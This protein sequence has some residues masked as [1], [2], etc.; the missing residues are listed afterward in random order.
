[1]KILVVDDEEDILTVIETLLS[2]T[3]PEHTIITVKESEKG[4][5]LIQQGGINLV[6]TDLRMAGMGGEGLLKAIQQFNPLI[7]VLIMS[8][9]GS[10][11][12]AVSLVKS[13]ARDFIT[14]PFR[15]DDFIHRV[16]L[17]IETLQLKQELMEVRQ[18]LHASRHESRLLYSSRAM[19]AIVSRASMAA[20]SSAPILISGE[21][22]T[23]KE[24]IAREI[25]ALSDRNDKPFIAIN[26]GAFPETLLEAELFGYRRGAFTGAVRDHAGIIMEAAEGTLF[27]D[28]IGETSL[29]FQVKLLRFI[30]EGEIRALGEGRTSR[31]NTRII[32][33]T[34]RDLRA[35]IREGSFRD[36]LFYRLNV[37]PIHIPP[38]RD[39][40][41]DILLL[42]NTFLK[43]FAK[44][45][46]RTLSLSPLAA[47]KLAGYSW[48][49]N[50]RELENRI[51][52]ASIL[53]RTNPILPED[54]E[55][56]D[57]EGE[58]ISRPP[59]HNLRFK[60]AKNRVVAAFER[61]YLARLMAEHRGSSTRAAA[62]AGIDRK[63]LWRLLKKH[64]LEVA[65]F[66][67]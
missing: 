66:K 35:M 5:E 30:Q 54:I 2:M 27:L 40:R 29:S 43:R 47:Q 7:P 65:H 24:L 64:G 53:A 62:A 39:R 10:I 52:Q 20:R 17:A 4:L 42:A 56:E 59:L 58:M 61:E 1:M 31:V 25:H 6:I 38:L 19:A 22:G 8:A 57:S 14:K 34:N 44:E 46:G 49:G 13:G 51:R 41:E 21:S 9:H 15:N 50:V 45:A 33:A 18:A 55:L 11:E 26:C 32:A 60:D 16:S 67:G 36:D 3:F 28:E 12:K 48:P 37:I 63:N 23:G